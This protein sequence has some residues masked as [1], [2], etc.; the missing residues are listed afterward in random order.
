MFNPVTQLNETGL[1]FFIIY[2]NISIG[3]Y[4]PIYKSEIKRAE[5]GGHRFNQVQIGASD[6]CRDE[7]EREI[8][9]EFFKS[10]PNGK[11]KNLGAVTLTL[12]MLKEG[13]AEHQIS[14]KAGTFN[15]DK[16]EIKAQHSFLEYVFGGCEIDLSMATCVTFL[17][18]PF[19]DRDTFRRQRC[20]E[21]AFMKN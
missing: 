18:W 1:C 9:F 3:Q 21:S 11:H 19:I 14:K 7:I 10:V 17:D 6:L 20:G 12:A 4:T 5:A 2:R 8:K 15:L 13:T 16:L